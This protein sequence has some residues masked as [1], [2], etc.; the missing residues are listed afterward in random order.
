LFGKSFDPHN[1]SVREF[2]QKACQHWEN[3]KKQRLAIDF[4]EE[5]F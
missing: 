4:T 2:F 5:T 1:V 3:L